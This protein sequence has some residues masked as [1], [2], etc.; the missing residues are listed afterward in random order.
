MV[1]LLLASTAAAAGPGAAPALAS[2]VAFPGV[3]PHAFAGTVV[4][5]A[6]EGRVAQVRT[7]DGRA[8]EVRGTPARPDGPGGATS[9]TTVDRTY[10]L[11]ARYEFHPVNAAAPFEDNSC[12]ATHPLPA[13]PTRLAE[14]APPDEAPVSGIAAAVGL[15]VAAT[16]VLVLLRRR[17]AE[18]HR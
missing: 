1:L 18:R 3:S 10:E 5:L 9:A 11:G 16:G 8:V 14:P 15:L 7:D 13:L 2:C 6:R 12:T 17:S 4:A